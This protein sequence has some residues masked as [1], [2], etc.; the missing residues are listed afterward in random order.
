MSWGPLLTEQQAAD[1]MELGVPGFRR[2][3]STLGILQPRFMGLFF[4]SDIDTILSDMPRYKR[5][6][7]GAEQIIYTSPSGLPPKGG[8]W[9]CCNA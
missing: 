4:R 7:H 2:C 1:Y 9:E 5:V 8:T 3:F 6:Y